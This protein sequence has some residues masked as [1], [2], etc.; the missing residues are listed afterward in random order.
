M[1]SL[2]KY[3][4]RF[5]NNTIGTDHTY[6]SPYGTQKIF[7]ADWVASGRLYRPIE[8]KLV[9]DFGPFVANTHTETSETGTLLTEAYHTARKIIKKHVNANNNDVLLFSGFGMTAA[10]NKFQR[11]LGLTAPEQLRPQ[12]HFDEDEIPLVVLTHMEHHS[13]QTSWLE[14]FAEVVVLEPDENGN[15]DLNKLEE[16]LKLYSKR[17]LKIGSFSAAS[18]VTGLQPPLN[19]MAEIMHRHG[20]LCFADFAMAAPY[21]PINMHPANPEERLDAIFFSP[22]KFLGGPGS[23]GVLIFNS[24]LYKRKVPDHPGGGTV[25]WTNPWGEHK[26]SDDIEIREDGGTPGFLEAIRGALSV[27]LKE[28]MT[29]ELILEREHELLEIAFPRFEKMENIHLLAPRGKKRLGV[30]SFYSEKVHY[31]L[32]V[33]LLSDIYGIQ[34]RGGCSCAGTYGHYLLHI[35][36][37]R[38]HNIAKEINHGDLSHKPGW[39]RL[40]LHPT[41]TNDELNY[42]LDAIEEINRDYEIYLKDYTYNP[43]TNEFTHKSGFTNKNLVEDWFGNL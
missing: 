27:K 3:F 23:S 12:I 43:K 1:N 40:S 32:F 22:H 13:N 36:P 20:G 25:D 8:D 33:K 16:V 4:L 21:V 19:K 38:S 35:D 30:L 9:N 24:D 5:R 31:N 6:K 15:V 37:T 18:N 39:V 42:I 11:I 7:Y 10:V 34:T 26:Y 17:K 41:M 2:E 28:E 14:T 29:A